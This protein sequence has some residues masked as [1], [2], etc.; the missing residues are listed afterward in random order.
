[1]TTVYR[2]Q[3]YREY[4]PEDAYGPSRGAYTS[5]YAFAKPSAVFLGTYTTKNRIE[6]KIVTAI[7]NM[8]YIVYDY[9]RVT[10]LINTVDIYATFQDLINDK[11]VGILLDS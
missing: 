4:I 10:G 9:G 1:M 6:E 5:F 3:V 11:G 2:I 8:S 7:G